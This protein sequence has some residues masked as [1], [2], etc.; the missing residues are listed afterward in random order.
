MHVAMCHVDHADAHRFVGL[1]I[2][3]TV[4]YADLA[5]DRGGPVEVAAREARLHVF[6]VF[7]SGGRQ[8]GG[9]AW[10]TKGVLRW[11]IPR[12]YGNGAQAAVWD[13]RERTVE[14]CARSE[15][16]EWSEWN[17]GTCKGFYWIM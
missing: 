2:S 6:V 9:S 16:L 7:V 11:R 10:R 5:E 14:D 17:P 4:L 1:R 3:S 12:E 15:G 13:Y 8:V